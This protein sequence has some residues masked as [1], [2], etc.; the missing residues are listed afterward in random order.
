MW[1]NVVCWKSTEV[2]EEHVASI[3]RSEKN[4]EQETNVKVRTNKALFAILIHA[5]FLFGAEDWG[6]I[7]LRNVGWLSTDY[8]ALYPRR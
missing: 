1:C 6:D 4:A 2:S 8:M 7:F 3:F 5:G